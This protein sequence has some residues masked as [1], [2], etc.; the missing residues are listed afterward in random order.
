M[1]GTIFIGQTPD[2][3]ARGLNFPYYSASYKS[4][5]S[6]SLEFPWPH[7]AGD[8]PYSPKQNLRNLPRESW[9][10]PADVGHYAATNNEFNN[11]FGLDNSPTGPALFA[12]ERHMKQLVD[13]SSSLDTVDFISNEQDFGA[14]TFPERSETCETT[15]SIPTRASTTPQRQTTPMSSPTSVN[16]AGTTDVNNH[17]ERNRV[18]ARKCR[19]KAKKNFAGLQQREKELSQQNKI[20]HSRVG[21]LRDQI[22]D[23]KNEILRHS[24]CNSSVIQDYI[25]KAARR[26]SA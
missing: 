20:L 26:Q 10:A 17:R 13:G 19:Q 16:S 15:P 25:T 23:L 4:E 5:E 24:A 1:D 22:L 21:G 7:P 6:P 14:E 12:Q 3:D 11:G 18:A 8:G 9:V 2:E